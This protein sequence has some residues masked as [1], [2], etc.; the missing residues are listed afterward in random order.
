MK[1]LDGGKYRMNI[2]KSNQ[3]QPGADM[4]TIGHVGVSDTTSV[5]TMIRRSSA[6][7]PCTVT[8]DAV[9]KVWICIGTESG[10]EATTTLYFDRNTVVFDAATDVEDPRNIPVRHQLGQNYPNPFN[11][12][13]M[14]PIEL[15]A[16]EHV[17]L[18]VYDITGR[19]IAVLINGVRDAG[20]SVV[21]FN[22]AGLASGV[23][24]YRLVAGRVHLA[25][26]MVMVR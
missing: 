12:V 10:F 15:V 4:D 16:E 1:I 2:D 26:T 6:T 9:G 24:I 7:H 20:R 13:T 21:P 25:R 3:G 18:R 22:A 17:D 8:A 19:E 11:P 23:Y 5:Y 14:I